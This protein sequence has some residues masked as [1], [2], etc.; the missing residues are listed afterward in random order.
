MFTYDGFEIEVERPVE[1]VVI[2]KLSGEIDLY[3][4]FSLME[5]VAAVVAERPELLAVD[6]SGVEFM[7]G[8]GVKV[9]ESAARHID[10]R[11][12]RF[13]VICP[14]RATAYGTFCSWSACIARPTCTSRRK[15]R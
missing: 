12:T 7:D 13:T 1:E 5:S 9:L 14:S 8:A 4:S 2:L 15:R 10:A 6:L 3:T 11:H